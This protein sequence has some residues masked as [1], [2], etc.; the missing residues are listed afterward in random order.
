MQQ[1][2]I[3]TPK[4]MSRIAPPSVISCIVNP[5]SKT[6]YSLPWERSADFFGGASR[7]TGY[8]TGSDVVAGLYLIMP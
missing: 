1:S 2:L 5:S 6:Y 4:Y 3:G 8:H 7:T